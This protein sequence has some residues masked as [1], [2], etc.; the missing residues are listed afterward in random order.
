MKSL[1]E[2]LKLSG[3]EIKNEINNM[4]IEEVM[5]LIKELEEMTKDAK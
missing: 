1:D 5:N 3:E 2:L 4:S